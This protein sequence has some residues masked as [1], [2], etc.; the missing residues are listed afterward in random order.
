MAVKFSNNAVTEL[1]S[2]ITAASTSISV[3]DGSVFPA[4]G[5]GEHTYVTLDSALTPVTLEIVK[6]TAISGNTLTVVRGQDGTTAASFDAGAKVE[7]RLTAALLN[8]VAT[9]AS[10]TNWADVQNKPD[11]TIYLSGDV[12]GQGTMTDVGD[13][14]IS[15]TVVDDSHNHT[16]ANVDGLQAALDAKYDASNPSGYLTGITGTQVTTALGYTPLS[17]SA[18]VTVS[19]FYNFTN[20]NGININ[21]D[22]YLKSGATGYAASVNL[23]AQRYNYAIISAIENTS[24]AERLILRGAGGDTSLYAGGVEKFTLAE[25]NSHSLTGSLT[26]NG[27]LSVGGNLN[28]GNFGIVGVDSLTF[29]DPGPN[30]GLTWN[31]GNIWRIYESPNDLTT[32][33]GGNLQ[34]VQNTTRRATFNTSGQLELPI[35]TGTAPL[36]VS[37]TTRV[38]NLNVATAGTADALT[39]ARTINGVSFNGT[40]NITVADST[41]LPLSGGTL[42]GAVTISSDDPTPITLARASAANSNI[43]YS[44][45]S[46]TV[47]AGL[48]NANGEFRVGTTNNLQSSGNVVLHA[49]N[50]NSYS[51]SLTGSGASG[52]WAISV[53]GNAATA[54]KWQTART[55]TLGGVLSGSVSLDGSAD[56]TLTAAHTSDPVITLTGAVT[57]SGTMTNLG[58]VSIATTATADPTLTL[59]GDVTGSATFTNL[60]NATLTTTVANDS[61]DHTRLLSVDDRDMKPNTSGIG[62][63]VQ[64]IKAFFSSLGGMTGAGDTDYQDVLVLDTYSDSSGGNPNAVTF[65]KSE[66]AVRV[67]QGGFNGTTWGT[68]QRVFLDNY[69]PNADKWTTARTITL[70]GVLSGS[71]SIDG[72][73][74]VTLTAAHTSDP[75]ITLTGA[76]TGSGTMTDL[77]SVSIA[78]TATSDPTLTLTGDVTGSA[79]FTNLGNAT[80]T[81]TVA[82]NSHNHDASN[83]N[84]GTLPDARLTGVYTNLSIRTDGGNTHYTTPN[85]GSS[86]TNDRTVFGL[87]QFKSDAS[88]ATGAIIFIAP[89]TT[90]SIMHR[91][92]IEG[93]IYSGGP[94]VCAIVQ[95]YRTTGAWSNTSKIN[96]GITDVQVRW[97]VDPSGKNCL[98]LGDVGTVWSYPML[99]I[100]HAMFS[101]SGSGDAYCTGWT[102][103]LVTS[104]TGYTNVTSTL[105][106]S[107][108]N[109]SITGNAGTATTL[110]TARTINGTSFN[111]SANITT[112]N[113]GTARTLTIGSTGKSVNG[114][115]NVSWSLTEIGAPSTTGTGASGTWGISIT[116]NAATATRLA[117]ARTING[118]SFNGSANITIADSTKLPLAGGTLTGNV[119][120]TAASVQSAVTGVSA[121]V[122]PFRTSESNIGTTAGYIPAFGQTS[123]YTS[124]YRSHMVL[125]SYRTASGWGGGPF[126]AWGGNDNNA[127]EAWLFNTGGSITHTGGRTFLDSSNYSNYTFPLGGSWYGSGLPGSRAYGLHVSGGEFVLGNGLPNAGQVGVLIDGCYVAGENNGFWSLASDNTW[128]SRRGM[129]WDGTYLNFTTNSAT[130]RHSAVYSDGN[131]TAYSDERVKTNWR[132]FGADFIERLAQ[133]KS[134]IYDRTDVES[135]TQVGVTAQSLRPV[136]EHAV[137][138]APTGELSVAYGNAALVAA[139]ELAKEVVNLRKEIELLKSKLH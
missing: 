77:G 96:L 39:T 49:G 41:K 19:G 102:V 128:G 25:N 71:V 124:G 113:W 107:A 126:L 133:V 32:N 58:S 89:N 4:L 18:N 137:V 69:H 81:A 76:V 36:L 132:N 8:D 88:A 53:S 59:T 60:G 70:G 21:S 136:M 94:T 122:S 61:H 87:A 13:V 112:A 72:S 134:G 24:N 119:T 129:Y 2:G 30:E 117:T 99:C 120:G 44:N 55:I 33:T 38:S 111:G 46:Y 97:G 65:D 115:A 106:N 131:V 138:E 100:T 109:T 10:V 130:T 83:I 91:L 51:P 57:G 6:V 34:I 104:L 11:P 78:T 74:N 98:I 75:V 40:A 54:S 35:A 84:A 63:G 45:S 79:T 67:W 108:V 5:A 15:V 86:S 26:V 105:P 43:A 20:A 56:V 123:V 50:Y 90:S 114:S 92:R 121:W 17:P 101:H 80:L 116:G 62:S 48:G 3:V 95:G 12:T 29:N 139:V 7:L 85:S 73:A 9:E 135:L 1:A 22:G 37:S 52:T 68:S 93:M 66:I 118:V 16:V 47:Y 27:S 14:T 28:M 23:Q 64:A 82:D 103:A 125:G 31:S 127:T 110:A 42:T